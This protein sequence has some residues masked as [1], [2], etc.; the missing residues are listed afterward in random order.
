MFL[1]QW[2]VMS[3]MNLIFQIACLASTEKFSQIS[4]HVLIYEFLTYLHAN[5]DKKASP[6]FA[7]F[8][9]NG[10]CY[11]GSWSKKTMHNIFLA[12]YPLN[13]K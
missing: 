8:Y 12:I 11:A 7:N 4:F 2:L 9:N 10:K 1:V 5:T 6:L 13:S 3:N